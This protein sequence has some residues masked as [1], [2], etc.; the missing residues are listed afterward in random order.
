MTSKRTPVKMIAFVL[1]L[2]LGAMVLPIVL[3]VTQGLPPIW[4]I[5][6]IMI[7]VIVSSVLIFPYMASKKSARMPRSYP[8]KVYELRIESAEPPAAAFDRIEKL[9][10]GRR[11]V[12]IHRHNEEMIISLGSDYRLRMHGVFSSSGRDALPLTA[13]VRAAT[14]DRGSRLE[15]SC[16]DDLG[17]FVGKQGEQLT[18]VAEL[19]VRETV[20]EIA[21][22]F[23]NNST[24]S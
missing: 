7:T 23:E 14:T 9:Y 11:D 4:L 13:T 21:N 12:S 15:I 8:P 6:G 3:T 10:T 17:W 24:R 22:T 19:K 20:Q 5:L 18:Q 1:I 2:A 16:S